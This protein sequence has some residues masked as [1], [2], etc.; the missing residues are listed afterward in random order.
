MAKADMVQALYQSSYAGQFYSK[1][2]D[3]IHK[4]VSD[5]KEQEKYNHKDTLEVAR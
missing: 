4:F 2:K 3:D 1:D 5:N